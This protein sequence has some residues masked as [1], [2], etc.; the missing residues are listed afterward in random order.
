[1]LV[2]CHYDKLN[3]LYVMFSLPYAFPDH[4]VLT[5]DIMDTQFNQTGY[6]LNDLIPIL[7]T[8]THRISIQTAPNEKLNSS[9]LTLLKQGTHRGKSFS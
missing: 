4:F 1:M 9:L 2:G 3:C 6:Q 5:T 7:F 8:K